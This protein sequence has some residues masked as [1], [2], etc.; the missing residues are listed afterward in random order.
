MIEGNAIFARD[1]VKRFKTQ[2]G[3]ITAV[4]HLSLEVGRG[5]TFGLIGPDGAGKTTTVRVIMGL[6]SRS[7]GESGILLEPRQPRGHHR[8]D[9]GD[10]AGAGVCGSLRVFNFR[11]Q[12]VTT[13]PC[14][15]SNTSLNPAVLNAAA[16]AVL[17]SGSPCTR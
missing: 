11:C 2:K 12:K 6:L 3:W 1:L 9:D 7:G 5:E 8:S 15:G 10:E 16:N 17:C 4:D 13:S 14:A